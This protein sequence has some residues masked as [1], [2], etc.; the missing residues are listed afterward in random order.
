MARRPRA[1]GSYE[2]VGPLFQQ[3]RQHPSRR[4]DASPERPATNGRRA[5]LS[6]R[7]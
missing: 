7:V 2:I 4:H 1:L 5:A 3:T 6:G